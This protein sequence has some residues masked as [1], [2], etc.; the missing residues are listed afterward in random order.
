MKKD[1]KCCGGL[2]PNGAIGENFRKRWYLV[3]D[4]KDEYVCY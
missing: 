4:L 3:W 2:L 1:T